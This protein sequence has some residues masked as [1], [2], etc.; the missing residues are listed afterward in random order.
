[1]HIVPVRKSCSKYNSEYLVSLKGKNVTLKAIHYHITKKTYKP[2][3]EM[4]E[5]A[6]G[7]TSFIDEIK[8][9]LGA[10]IILIHNIDTGDGLA[11]GQLGIL[12]DIIYTTDGKPD[13][14]IFNLQKSGIGLQNRKRFPNIAR[15]FPH[16]VIIEKVSISYSI[17]KKGGIV[18]STATQFPM[19][20]ANASP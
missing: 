10:K 14:L 16:S 4:K 1:M 20:L 8:V 3:I 13:K 9:K 18:G 5:G 6:I 11:N 17:R 15:K 12:A 2:F 19:K 7:T